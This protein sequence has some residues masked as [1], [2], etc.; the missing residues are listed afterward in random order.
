MRRLWPASRHITKQ[1]K[2][3]INKKLKCAIIPFIN[4]LN[5]IVKL[6]LLSSHADQQSPRYDYTNQDYYLTD[7]WNDPP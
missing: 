5:T 6:T 3:N 1:F 7:D 4:Y 2:C